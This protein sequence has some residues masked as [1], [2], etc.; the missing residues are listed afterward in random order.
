LAL[1]LYDWRRDYY[2]R[3]DAP[4]LVDLE[5]H[6]REVGESGLDLS[7]TV[8]WFTSVYPVRLDFATIDLDAAFEGDAAAG[9]A[10]RQMK[11]ELRRT[12]DRGLGYGLLR[13]LNEETGAELS[14]LPQA[15]I[16]FNYLGR[17]EEIASARGSVRS[18]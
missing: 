3:E 7:R 18:S 11:E 12:S 10:L 17:F 1:A 9:Y 15:E 13:R 14:R 6:G 5:G 4:L 16:A 2:G 8:G